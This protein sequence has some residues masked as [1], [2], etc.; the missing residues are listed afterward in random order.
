MDEKDKQAVKNASRIKKIRA[1][2]GFHPFL[3]YDLKSG[4][5]EKMKMYLLWC[6]DCEQ[7]VC[8]YKHGHLGYL[9]CPECQIKNLLGT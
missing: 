3:G 8:N 6:K 2:M 1:R 7:Y 5:S 9:P 4:W